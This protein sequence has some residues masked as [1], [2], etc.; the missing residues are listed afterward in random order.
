MNRL[1]SDLG[2]TIEAAGVLYARRQG[3]DVDDLSERA[4]GDL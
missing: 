3:V 2:L 4:L 1:Q